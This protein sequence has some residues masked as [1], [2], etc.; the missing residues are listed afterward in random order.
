MAKIGRNSPCPC[1]SGRKYKRC[2][3]DRETAMRNTEPPSGRFQFEPGSYGGSGKYMPSLLCYKETGPD[4]WEEDYCLVTPD[5]VFEDEA[6]ATAAAR[7]HLDEAFAA[8][9][10]GGSSAEMA[11]SLRHE[12]YKK[13]EDYRVIRDEEQ[14]AE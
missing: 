9:D 3:L 1:G 11:I 7:Q 6:S 5:K 8:R 13:V 2:C 4:S 14:D 12:G 10:E